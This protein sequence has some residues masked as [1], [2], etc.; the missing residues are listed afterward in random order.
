MTEMF[1]EEPTGL[2]DLEGLEPI[3]LGPMLMRRLAWDSLP[4]GE[5]EPLLA[6]LG[7]TPTSPDGLEVEHQQSHVRV[8]SVMPLE[9]VLV[10]A[11]DALG[12]IV[13]MAMTENKGVTDAVDMERFAEQNA[14]VVL[15]SARAIIATLFYENILTYTPEAIVAMSL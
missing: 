3:D 10:K 2:E 8:A 13:S 4:C 15:A 7:L 12:T 14:E 6:L 11:S 5:V 9:Q 1:P